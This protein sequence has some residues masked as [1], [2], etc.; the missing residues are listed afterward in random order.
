MSRL[1]DKPDYNEWA[2]DIVSSIDRPTSYAAEVVA[3]SSGESNGNSLG[4]ATPRGRDPRAPVGGGS[5][6]TLVRM[7]YAAPARRGVTGWLAFFSGSR[8]QTAR[9]PSRGR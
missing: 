7:F 4:F 8:L 5:V 1:G 6:R 2:A 3:D 9:R